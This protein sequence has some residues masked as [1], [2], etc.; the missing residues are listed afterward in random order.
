M[1][2]KPEDWQ[3]GNINWLLDFIALD[4]A[5]TGWVTANF[6]QVVKEGEPRVHPHIGGLV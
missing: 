5:R 6:R 3:S 1:H 4:R 2:L